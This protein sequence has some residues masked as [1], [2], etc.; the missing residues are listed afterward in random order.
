MTRAKNELDLIVP[1]RSLRYQQTKSNERYTYG[2][3][4]RFIPADIRHTFDC[5]RWRDRN[6]LADQR[7]GNAR[8]A[9]VARYGDGDRVEA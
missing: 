8:R 3:I 4:S 9:M 7:S 1:E 2:P 5:R 6:D